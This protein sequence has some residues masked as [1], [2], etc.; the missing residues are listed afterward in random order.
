[1][2]LARII[3]K[4]PIM[5][6]YVSHKITP[7]TNIRNMDSERSRVERDR[8]A[9]TAWGK[10]ARVVQLPARIPI[11]VKDCMLGHRFENEES[12]RFKRS[13]NPETHWT[14]SPHFAD[15]RIGFTLRQQRPCLGRFLGAHLLSGFKGG[16][17]TDRSRGD[18]LHGAAAGN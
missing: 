18:V 16:L 12:R 3:G 8:Q 6:P 14:G 10:K 13:Y 1:M 4:S 9:L 17:V 7:V 11:K 5:S 2:L 15:L